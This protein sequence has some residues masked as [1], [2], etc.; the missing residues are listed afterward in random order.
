MTRKAFVR[1]VGSSLGIS[2]RECMTSSRISGYAWKNDILYIIFGTS[3]KKSSLYK[4]Y[5]VSKEMFIA[6]DNSKSKGVWIQHN[7]IKPKVKYEG[8]NIS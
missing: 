8:F 4:Y 5:G 6:L 3:P 2:F 7:L 1:Y